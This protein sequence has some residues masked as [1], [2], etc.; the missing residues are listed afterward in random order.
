MNKHKFHKYE[1]TFFLDHKLMNY[2]L[3]F[4]EQLS[5]LGYSITVVHPG[6]IIENIK[7]FHQLLS[8]VIDLPG[9]IQYRI[10]RKSS[11]PN[12][13]VHMQNIRILNLWFLTLNPF[14]KYK[15]IHWGIGV[16]SS[17][18]LSLKQTPISRLRGFLS[19]FASAVVLY[20][21]YAIPLFPKAV[22][23][24]IF[25]ANN[26][27]YNPRIADFSLE[28]KSSF[29]FIG[30]L[31]ARKGLDDLL[32]AFADLVKNTNNMSV[33]LDIIGEGP[34]KK[35]LIALS[36]KLG[37]NDRTNFLGQISSSEEKEHCFKRAFACISPKQ[38][39]LSVLESFSY[40]VPFI[41]YKDAISGGEHL[42]IQNNVNGYLINDRIE[43]A[44]TLKT[45][46]ENKQLS[47]TLGTN[48]FKYYKSKR[49]MKHM[50]EVFDLA[51]KSVL[52][53]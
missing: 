32:I 34:E 24:K 10:K 38:A 31:N 30:S 15:V 47:A 26:T 6:P 37:I 35:N 20:S 25:I 12:I 16:S 14:T 53:K 22:H 11:S 1:I 23:K 8:D 17:K 44:S 43:L 18:G 3:D 51:F 48:A 46:V 5:Y 40:G 9:G 29:L 45:M 52:Q 21:D 39:G 42:N 7:L 36:N 33:Q 41:A 50:V 27:V 19:R 49:Q 28:V 2:R 13:I 4:F